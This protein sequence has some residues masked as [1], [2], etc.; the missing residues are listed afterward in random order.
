MSIDPVLLA[1]SAPSLP[2]PGNDEPT[3]EVQAFGPILANSLK[4][5]AELIT[6]FDS[7][8]FAG[9][10]SEACIGRGLIGVDDDLEIDAIDTQHDDETQSLPGDGPS[11][12]TTGDNESWLPGYRSAVKDFNR[13]Q[14]SHLKDKPA[15]TSMSAF[16]STAD[17]VR[18]DKVLL[19]AILMDESVFADLKYP[20]SGHAPTANGTCPVINCQ[21]LR[22]SPSHILSH[23]R[24][25]RANAYWDLY[26]KHVPIH[27][28]WTGCRGAAITSAIELVGHLGSHVNTA[29]LKSTQCQIPHE[30]G[31][32]CEFSLVY[33]HKS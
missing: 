17:K 32:V 22:P 27:C 21:E 3:V 16:F 1:L 15:S 11:A 24:T 23:A 14:T 8:D 7:A 18:Q 29:R 5:S 33:L 12:D 28:P 30:D 25:H 13:Q 9:D 4:E 2:A 20:Y 31:S 26:A 10:D 19:L 6:N